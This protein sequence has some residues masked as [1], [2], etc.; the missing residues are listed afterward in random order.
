MVIMNFQCRS[1]N[2]GS[3][4][5]FSSFF[6]AGFLFLGALPQIFSNVFFIRDARS[7]SYINCN[8]LFFAPN[9]QMAVVVFLFCFISA[10]TSLP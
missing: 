1:M 4:V 2:Q 5:K 6:T 9:T 8:W 7:T 10:Q 3:I